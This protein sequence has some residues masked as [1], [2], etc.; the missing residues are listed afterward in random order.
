MCAVKTGSSSDVCSTPMGGRCA[1]RGPHYHTTRCMYHP[2]RQGLLQMPP[3]TKLQLTELMVTN[4]PRSSLEKR[5]PQSILFPKLEHASPRW[6]RDG[7]L[8]LNIDSL[9]PLA[10]PP[11]HPSLPSRPSPAHPPWHPVSPL[12]HLAPQSLA[13]APPPTTTHPKPAVQ[14]THL[15]AA[16]DQQPCRVWNPTLAP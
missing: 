7:K 12:L 10:L 16:V 2:Q 6:P 4:H 3:L 15:Q 14:D 1:S 9:V 11:N 8:P 13:T 5:Y